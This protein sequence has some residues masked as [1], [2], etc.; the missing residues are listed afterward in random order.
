[1]HRP[2]AVRSR[3]QLGIVQRRAFATTGFG[4]GLQPLSS[5]SAVSRPSLRMAI[6]TS[7]FFARSLLASA[8]MRASSTVGTFT[9]MSLVS[10]GPSLPRPIRS[11]SPSFAF[12]IFCPPP[13]VAACCCEMPPYLDDSAWLHECDNSPFYRQRIGASTP[14]SA[15][16]WVAGAP[17]TRTDRAACIAIAESRAGSRK[18]RHHALREQA[19]RLAR[20]AAEELD[21]EHRA[22]ERQV[23]AD[24]LDA[25]FRRAGDAHGAAGAHVPA[26]DLLGALHLRLGIGV[27]LA[28]HHHALL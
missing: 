1:M 6:T 10:S 25:L 18:R 16:R 22:A 9:F 2:F 12:R 13:P 11:S 28:D 15:G 8:A 5:V 24:R 17:R 14:I 27:V 19:R 20:V 26:V 23:L 3:S 7:V 21:D 4:G